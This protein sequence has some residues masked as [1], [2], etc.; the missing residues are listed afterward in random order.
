MRGRRHYYQLSWSVSDGPSWRKRNLAWSSDRGMGFAMVE[1][2]VRR[3]WDAKPEPKQK[4][5]QMT[6]S[7]VFPMK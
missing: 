4:L 1:N 2:M 5:P 3:P 7:R 6:A